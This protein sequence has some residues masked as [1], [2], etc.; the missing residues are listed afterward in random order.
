MLYLQSIL[1][2]WCFYNNSL[3][4]YKSI[5]HT[6]NKIAGFVKITCLTAAIGN[7]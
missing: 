7:N 3:Y 4:Y 5:H 6:S 2:D 1:F